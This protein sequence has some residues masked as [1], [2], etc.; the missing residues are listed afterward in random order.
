MVAEAV[1][2]REPDLGEVTLRARAVRIAPHDTGLHVV[3]PAERPAT[4]DEIYRRYG[5]YVAAIVLRLDG[6]GP[7]LEDL[8]QDVFVEAARGLRGLRDAEAIK[9]WLATIAVRTVRQRLRRR[10]ARR[11]LGLDASPDYER[12]VDPA[13][14]P[15]DRILIA[16]VYRV[17]DDLPVQDRLAFSLHH[18][19][20][21]KVEA[22]AVLCGCSLATA[23]RR[24][25]RALAT[26][27]KKLGD[28]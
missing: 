18:L 8:V 20:G 14:S 23:K 22:V 28:G 15:L 21:E 4:L 5:R 13:A 6:R 10:R 19:Q 25:A 26:I 9:G 3:G 17:L 24:I 16:S 7:E 2:F 27:G 12:L 11:F 1:A